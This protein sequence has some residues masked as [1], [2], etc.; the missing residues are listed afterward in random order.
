V[1]GQDLG[2]QRLGTTVGDGLTE[3][4]VLKAARRIPTPLRPLPACS[5]DGAAR[6]GQRD[7]S[8][9]Q[10]RLHA[11]TDEARRHDHAGVDQ[12]PSGRGRRY[13]SDD[14][15]VVWAQVRHPVNEHAVLWT[16]DAARAT[17]LDH[18][19]GEAAESPPCDGRPV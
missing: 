11:P 5:P 6:L 17:D 14:L 2:K 12:R 7:E 16:H 18:A 19:G 3:G 8:V 13:T 9:G 10:P 4:P 1:G 15:D